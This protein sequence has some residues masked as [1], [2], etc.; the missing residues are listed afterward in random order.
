MNNK[1]YLIITDSFS[2][3]PEI[4]EISKADSHNTIE[5]LKETFTRYGLPDTV[6]TDNGTPFTSGELS[7]FCELNG[8]KHLTSSSWHP[9]SNG[10]AENAVKSF[11]IGFS[12]IIMSKSDSST[13][14]TINKYLFYY[15]NSVHS[16]TGFTPSKLMFGREAN[17]RLNKIKP[18]PLNVTASDRQ[19][20]NYKGNIT[21]KT[22]LN[23]AIVFIRDYSKPNKKGWK[24]YIIDEIL[25]NNIYI[26]KDQSSNKYFKRHVDQI[27]KSG[28]YCKNAEKLVTEP[29]ITESSDGNNRDKLLEILDC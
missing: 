4:F 27:I 16:I 12:K 3:W 7:E 21:N 25:G 10:A 17:I 22:F 23:N 20:R 2:K 15:R 1:M 9:S 14:P 11:K 18:K 29:D 28:T 13:E 26:C 5:K 19:I 24:T 6:V 8:I